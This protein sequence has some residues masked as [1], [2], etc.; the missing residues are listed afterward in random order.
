MRLPERVQFAAAAK[1]KPAVGSDGQCGYGNVAELQFDPPLVLWLLN[2]PMI[3]R[4][5][6]GAG[7]M[8]EAFMFLAIGSRWATFGVG[9]CVIAMHLTIAE[10]MGLLFPSHVAFLALFWV[11]PLPISLVQKSVVRLRSPRIA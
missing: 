7:F 8:L 4:F 6:F 9:M 1:K 10:T 5:I 3:S 11:L 2:H